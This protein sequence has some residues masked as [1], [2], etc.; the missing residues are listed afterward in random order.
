MQVTEVSLG[1]G[2]DFPVGLQEKPHHPVG[3]GMLGTHV[4]GA[5]LGGNRHLDLGTLSLGEGRGHAHGI[6][7]YSSGK[8]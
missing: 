1:S 4:D 8:T 7:W 5:I 2:Q 6:P 3:G